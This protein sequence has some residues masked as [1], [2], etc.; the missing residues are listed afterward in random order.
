MNDDTQ[1]A[2]TQKGARASNR[3][4]NLLGML[5]GSGL[6][7][8]AILIP[9]PPR[10]LVMWIGFSSIFGLMGTLGVVVHLCRGRQPLATIPAKAWW[11]FMGFG[12]LCGATAGY[13]AW[14]C[15]AKLP[16]DAI[17][18]M[19]IAGLLGGFA[20]TETALRVSDRERRAAYRERQ[21][22]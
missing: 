11:A 2:G 14:K 15:G 12:V 21:R 5:I 3:K 9:E 10:T 13:E 8:C 22:D 7:A 18:G 4:W 6:G 19:V 16:D 17:G 20:V 1:Q